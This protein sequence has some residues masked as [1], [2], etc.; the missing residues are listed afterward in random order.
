MGWYAV[1]TVLRNNRQAQ[2]P[3]AVRSL[4]IATFSAFLIDNI[5]HDLQR[6]DLGFF[7]CKLPTHF[8]PEQWGRL[9]A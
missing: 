6:I 7:Y 2:G 5:Q 8:G 9:F 4:A 3:K 1:L